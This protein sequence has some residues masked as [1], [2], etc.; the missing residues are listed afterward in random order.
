MNRNLLT[1]YVGSL[2]EPKNGI[3]VDISHPPEVIVGIIIEKLK[4]SPSS[5]C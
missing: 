3:I 1:S 4:W 5:R 2:E